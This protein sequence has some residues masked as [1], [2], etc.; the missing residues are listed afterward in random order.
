M[1]PNREPQTRDAITDQATHCFNRVIARFAAGAREG[2]ALSLASAKCHKITLDSRP[3]GG[4]W[5]FILH[6]TRRGN[7]DAT[8]GSHVAPFSVPRR[9][10]FGGGTS[11]SD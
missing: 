1:L 7:T 9:P 5:G 10:E 2:I 3:L 4:H 11:I 8:L 6:A